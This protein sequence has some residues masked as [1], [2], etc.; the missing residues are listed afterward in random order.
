MRT[1]ERFET[2]DGLR[3]IAAI[4]VMLMHLTFF[5]LSVA[6]NGYLAVD[7]F[8]V[9]SGYVMS[10]AYTQRLEYMSFYR[11][12][13]LRLIRLLPLSLMGLL[14]GTCYFLARACF[15]P[16][17][18]YKVPDILGGAA[19]NAFL[20]P[21][22]WI[23]APP[24]DTIFPTDPP[25]WSLS[26]EVLL[27]FVWAAFLF[28]ARQKTLAI[29][30][31]IAGAG[32]VAYCL[33]NGTANLGA[34]WST[35]LGGLSRATFGF[36]LGVLLWRNRLAP[37]KANRYA[38]LSALMLVLIILSPDVGPILEIP[39]ILLVVPVVVFIATRADHTI[40]RPFFR[41][42]GS[43][44]YPLYVV[45][46]PIYDITI[47]VAKLLKVY[48]HVYI[49]AMIAIA[50]SLITA[51]VLDRFYDKPVRRWLSKALRQKGEKGLGLP[52]ETKGL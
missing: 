43:I 39:V 19:F 22:P 14:I 9:L 30:L 7:F 25:L 50:V 10:H 3:G 17:S 6:P 8:F 34:L 12:V 11:F 49:V 20:I 15:L 36:L 40:E 42:V 48:D 26:L 44:S 45:H 21:K 1:E 5:G 28:K 38:E 35:Y 2:L 41:I 24:T 4:G 31:L 27:N 16:D 37:G 47:G 33:Y 29:I 52:A 13:Q 23:S 51:F 18:L 32:V 46:L